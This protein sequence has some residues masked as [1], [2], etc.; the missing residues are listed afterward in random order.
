M[1]KA[2]LILPNQLFEDSPV[3]AGG[4]DVFLLEH[5]RYFSQ[6]RFHR[7]KLLF[8]R[9]SM[10]AY[11]ETLA[12]KGVR[13]HYVP[14][15]K[16]FPKGG[17]TH[18]LKQHG[19]RELDV[20]DPCDFSCREELEETARRL[21]G[22]LRIHACPQFLCDAESLET[23]FRGRKRFSMATFYAHQRKRLGVLVENGKPVGGKWS[24][25]TE[26]RKRLPVDLTIP[27]LPAVPQ[28]KHV[29][30]ARRYVLKHF[31]DHPG[32]V[33]GFFYP[34]THEDARM[35]LQD[36]LKRG[37]GQFGPYE[38][39]ISRTEPFL[40]HS[41]LSPL[42]NA[43][44]LI[45]VEV[46][47]RTLEHGRH[48]DIPLNSLEGFIRQIIGWREFM[49]AVYLRIGTEQR[50][51]N[52]WGFEKQMPAAFY[53]ANTGIEPVDTVIERVR[54]NAFAHHIERLMVLG[55]FFLLC[56]VRPDEVYRWFMELFID[57]YDW[58][59]V[60]NVYGMSQYADGGRI[61]TKPYISSSNY[62]RKMSDFARGS[63]CDVWDALF[64]RFIH[65][66]RDVFAG[67]PRMGVMTR[68]W[69][70][71]NPQKRKAHLLL[72][73]RYLASLFR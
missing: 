10:K 19:V 47:E 49:R 22:E 26:N 20:V 52:F 62:I 71:M 66:H 33:D 29:E 43:G 9:A 65:K 72:G 1:K 8:H 36:F 37:L 45:P 6:F 63:W 70:R 54:R 42:I 24:F 44:L 35:W 61:T 32:A 7:Q 53:Q 12:R 16:L 14:H 40:F 59:M 21:K 30:Q 48:H 67:N 31:P 68:Q 46:V 4:G 64:W 2:A 50:T 55:N 56:E 5:P 23:F 60:P 51:A 15:E 57:A 39:A 73:E 27:A 41:L 58:V 13:V 34:V 3:L 69:D 18:L 11:A 17:L 38:D 28:R 25:D